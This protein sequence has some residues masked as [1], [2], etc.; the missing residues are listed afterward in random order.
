MD[1]TYSFPI[2]FLVSYY[3]PIN[4]KQ[5]IM[6][7][8]LDLPVS[9]SFEHVHILNCACFLV[10]YLYNSFIVIFNEFEMWLLKCLNIYQ[11]ISKPLICTFF[12][13]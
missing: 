13:K 11:N 10:S 1:V 8:A 7:S 5:T 3:L 2:S 9:S 6:H 4:I 12:M